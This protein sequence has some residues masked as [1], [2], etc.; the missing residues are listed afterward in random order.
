[1]KT[2]TTLP[3]KQLAILL[4]GDP[5]SR[6]TTLA[7][8]FPRPYIFDA[9]GNMAAPLERLSKTN[10]N[11]PKSVF[12]DGAYV[13]DAGNEIPPAK[14]YLHMTACLTLAGTDPNIRTIIIDSCTSLCDILIAEVKRQANRG[15][16]QEMRIQ[17]WGK[18]AELWK[19]LIIKLRNLP[20]KIIVFTAHNKV[21]KDESDGRW[22]YFLNIPG[23]TS[24][25]LS[26]L[27]TDVWNPY[28][29][30]SGVGAA[31]THQAKVRCL[32]TNDVDH[33]G[34]KSSF[35]FKFVEDYDTVVKAIKT[36]V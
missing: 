34:M 24:T 3:P 32:P 31:T 14:R 2:A 11:L 25:N 1:M 21:E 35:D 9:D 29:V 30:F 28:T 22:K 7:L 8:Q 36:L 5:G 17:D 23:Q 13:D 4:V 26:G 19:N 15:Q 27:F 18:F 33:R 12:Y 16:D 20:G 6:K 10:P